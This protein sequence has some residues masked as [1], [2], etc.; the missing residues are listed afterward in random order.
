MEKG[1][2]VRVKKDISGS[3]PVGLVGRICVLAN[4]TPSKWYGI[5]FAEPH[6]G[7]HDCDGNCKY[8]HG[9]YL[10]IDCFEIIRN[11][12]QGDKEIVRKRS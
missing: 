2:L 5:E 7:M 9:Y 10:P 12:W 11:V 4:E 8:G 1:T 3:C 6:K